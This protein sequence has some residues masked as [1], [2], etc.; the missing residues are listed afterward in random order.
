MADSVEHEAAVDV[1]ERPRRPLPL[2][3]LL[4]G[5][6]SKVDRHG[7][8]HR[9]LARPQLAP[10]LRHSPPPGRRRGGHRADRH[11]WSPPILRCARR[12]PGRPGVEG[13]R[14]TWGYIPWAPRC[15]GRKGPAVVDGR[16]VCFRGFM[17]P[18]SGAWPK[19]PGSPGAGAPATSCAARQSRRPGLYGPRRSWRAGPSCPPA[20]RRPAP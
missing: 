17:P 5:S 12:P 10:E 7:M 13:V 9:Q 3:R 16:H 15:G 8:T 20:G 18:G 2:P 14:G 19:G 1:L 6:R 11:A 4:R